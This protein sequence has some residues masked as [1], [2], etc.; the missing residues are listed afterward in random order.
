MLYRQNVSRV[1]DWH[2][3]CFNLKTE[4]IANNHA[5]GKYYNK[6]TN[7]ISKLLTPTRVGFNSILINM[8][9][10]SIL[11]AYEQ[12]NLAL[13]SGDESKKEQAKNRYEES[14]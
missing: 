9:R 13:Q 7:T 3:F 11:K 4:I 2:F 1:H 10:T 5:I 14:Y 6:I 12:Y 8:K